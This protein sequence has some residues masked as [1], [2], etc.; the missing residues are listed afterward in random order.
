MQ[1]GAK[2]IKNLFNRDIKNG[3]EFFLKNLKGT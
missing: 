3:V 2:G 1:I